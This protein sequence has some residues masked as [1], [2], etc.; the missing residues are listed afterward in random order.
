MMN[1]RRKG[2]T[3][4]FG[5]SPQ[6]MARLQDILDANG[7][8]PADLAGS[9][10][11]SVSA[12][13]QDVARM[14]AK[15]GAR[16]MA[17]LLTV[18]QRAGLIALRADVG[19]IPS[20]AG[21]NVYR[22]V[23]E[24]SAR[25]SYNIPILPLTR[26]SRASAPETRKPT[27]TDVTNRPAPI[28]RGKHFESDPAVYR[29]IDD[30]QLAAEYNARREQNNA[31]AVTVG[32]PAVG[33]TML[34]KYGIEWVVDSHIHVPAPS[35]AKRW[36]AGDGERP[37][38][39]YPSVIPLNL[40][41]RLANFVAAVDR[42][43]AKTFILLDTTPELRPSAAPGSH[44]LDTI[45]NPGAN[46]IFID[47][48]RL[49]E[50]VLAHEI[51]H[52]WVQYVERCE[53]E[54]VMEDVSDPQRL[55]QLHFVQSFVLD[56]KVNEV[57]ARKGF[58]MHPIE[59]DQAASILALC[60]ALESGYQPPNRRE[61][62][63][64]ALLLASQMLAEDRDRRSALIHSRNALTRIRHKNE[65]LGRLAERFAV[66][67]RSHDINDRE[68]IR[69]AIDECL[70]TA[71][72]FTG[73]GINL[74]ADLITPDVEEPNFDK[75]PQWIQ[76]A[77]V[78]LKTEIGRVMAREE[79]PDESRWNLSHGPDSRS[80]LSF[81][82]PDGKTV[83]PWILDYPYPFDRASDALRLMEINRVN[84]QRLISQMPQGFGNVPGHC[85]MPR[86]QGHRHYMA[87]LG[88]FL[89]QARLDAQLRGEHPYSYA[90]NNPVTYSDPSGE[91][92]DCIRRSHIKKIPCPP[93][94]AAAKTKICKA[95]SAS[96]QAGLVATKCVTGPRHAKCLLDWC[97]KGNIYCHPAAS[98]G[99]CGKSCSDPKHQ[100]PDWG[101]SLCWPSAANPTEC[102]PLSCSSGLI[103]TILHE[104][105]GVCG[106]PHDPETDD[107]CEV[108]ANCLCGALGI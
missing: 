80:I 47:A 104:M 72:E 49:H 70:E 36:R 43:T 5:F 53:D 62:V 95:L 17:E 12:A 52:A 21:E 39:L 48:A 82:C 2:S 63:F 4:P 6:Q 29:R 22:G 55:H 91:E 69:R 45:C 74:A 27:M 86:H 75:Y 98:C 33:A 71:F 1:Q 14:R 16:T 77:P 10:G 96:G 38:D 34:N 90:L 79:I 26:L 94:V 102:T 15:C 73:D 32:L 57:I 78:R 105:N 108:P 97:A 31:L 103:A 30:E 59:S 60:Q 25:M 83:G 56:L 51:G 85:G 54:R 3:S 88:R 65:S 50:T 64:M 66:A 18:A 28:Q 7:K 101:I 24:A 35:T 100:H 8:R 68:S 93:S 84:R 92:P 89:T 81:E 67:V 44:S 76:G 58:D 11:V 20:Q 23:L 46:I 19:S 107:P 13:N 42:C 87:G 40:S 9:W 99:S 61:E 106:V 41:P 37:D